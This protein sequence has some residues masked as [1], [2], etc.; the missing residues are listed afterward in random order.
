[1]ACLMGD[2][3]LMEFIRVKK[4]SDNGCAV[5]LVNMKGEIGSVG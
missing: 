4:Q 2:M 3:A 5:T 1:M